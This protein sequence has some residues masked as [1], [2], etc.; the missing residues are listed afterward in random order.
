MLST[1]EIRRNHQNDN[2]QTCMENVR[3][4]LSGFLLWDTLPFLAHYFFGLDSICVNFRHFI[5]CYASKRIT[6]VGRNRATRC[7]H[8]RAEN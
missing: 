2:F 1:E 4:G 8:D 5:V 7:P 6:Y 3:F